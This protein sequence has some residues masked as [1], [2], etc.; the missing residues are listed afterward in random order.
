MGC[1]VK[2]GSGSS[3]SGIGMASAK[4]I[5]TIRWS[6]QEVHQL[7][8]PLPL[9]GVIAHNVDLSAMQGPT[10]VALLTHCE[11]GHEAL[12]HGGLRRRRSRCRADTP[13]A[14]TVV[15][16]RCLTCAD[17]RLC[18]FQF[19][20]S[21]CRETFFSTVGVPQSVE[22]RI[23]LLIFGTST[24]AYS[25]NPRTVSSFQS[26]QHFRRLSLWLSVVCAQLAPA[27]LCLARSW[28]FL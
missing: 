11:G 2:T 28:G 15:S 17:P 10:L 20:R 16:S 3:C 14:S 12:R 13:P 27:T 18:R 21:L 6:P 25:A 8:A 5:P 7:V 1:C 26:V 22:M 23:K 24:F 9:C 19:W 4:F